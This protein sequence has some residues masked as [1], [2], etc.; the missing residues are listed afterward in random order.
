MPIEL[1]VTKPMKVQ[2]AELR[3]HCKVRDEF[4]ASLV[5]DRGVVIHAQDEGYVP[6]FM[7]G[8]HYGDYVVLNIDLESGR[9]TNWK[10][11]APKAIEA[12]INGGDE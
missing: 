6:S 9:I 12:W 7:P 11:P 2:A 4:T 8:D 1:S 5:D 10:T 3:I